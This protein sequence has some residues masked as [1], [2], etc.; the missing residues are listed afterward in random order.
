MITAIVLYD[1]S[2]DIGLEECRA[3]FTKIAPD[4]L[5]IPGFL[6]KQFIC[7]RDGKVAGGVYMWE[8]QEAAERFYSGEWLAGIRAR[9]GTEPTISYYETVA[10]TD[11][12]SGHAGGLD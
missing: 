7:A 12:A 6:R 10:L 2:P 9:Y 1:L 5:K 8:S 11:K 3:H 4:F